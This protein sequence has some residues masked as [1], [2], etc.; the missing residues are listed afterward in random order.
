M[1]VIAFAQ[2]GI[3]AW[4]FVFARLAGWSTLDPVLARLPVL[5]R[6]AI[7]AVLAAA[8]LPSAGVQRVEPFSLAGGVALALE[9]LLG[10]LL[11][12]AVR[13]LFAAT[14]AAL[15][16]IGQGASGGLLALTD[17]QAAPANRSLR[18]LGWWLAVLAFLA[19]NGHLI[20]I[21][22]LQQSL[23]HA[24]VA[25][26]PS[27]ATIR[28]LFDGAGWIFAAGFQLA[29]P[30]LAFAL[31]LQLAFGMLA[32]TQPG[33]DMLSMGLT[34][35]ALGLLAALLWAVPL[36]ALGIEQGLARLQLWLPLW[37]S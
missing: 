5:L 21:H 3:A 35:G 2:S 20:V 19:A 23:I 15:V 33:V 4:L 13:M 37:A 27:A 6:L 14:Q 31:L 12:L 1:A 26:L 9:W 24:P 22:A 8:L 16:W 17:A 18:Q 32:R 10:A 30:L 11:A 29:L 7:A 36:I 34:L 25:T 28:Q